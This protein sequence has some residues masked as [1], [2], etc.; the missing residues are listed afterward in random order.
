MARGLLV[1][2]SPQEEITLLRIAN[3]VHGS[4]GLRKGNVTRLHLLNLV[5][6]RGQPYFGLTAS[7]RGGLTFDL[8]ALG[9]ETVARLTHA[10]LHP[11]TAH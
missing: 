5:E 3:G 7:S 8:T 9:K 6:E 2:L 10:A 1:E 11:H 4:L